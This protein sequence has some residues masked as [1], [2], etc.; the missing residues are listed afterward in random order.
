MQG[1][2]YLFRGHSGSGKSTRAK[3]MCHNLEC[4]HVEADMFFYNNKE[5]KYFWDINLLKHAH[6]WCQKT[7]LIYLNQGYDVCVSNTFTRLWEMKPYFDMAKNP[8]QVFRCYG[9]YN[10][11]HNVP[12]AVVKEQIRRFQDYEGEAVA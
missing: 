2:L 6:D 8:V 1:Y 4:V 7:T 10:N 9:N 12:D 3:A 5:G 11:V